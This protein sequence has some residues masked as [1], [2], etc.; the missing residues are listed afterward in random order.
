[1]CFDGLTCRIHCDRVCRALR[2][3]ARRECKWR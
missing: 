2:G 3:R 1:L